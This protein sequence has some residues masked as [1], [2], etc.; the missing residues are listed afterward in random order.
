MQTQQ[1]S[2]E[3]LQK[4]VAGSRS[5]L[6]VV[7]IFTVLNIVLLL[8]DSG[9]YFLFSASGPYYATAFGI[10]MD[11]G[12]LQMGYES[13]VFTIIALVLSAVVLGLLLLCWGMSKKKTGWLTAAF[14]IMVLDTLV[15]LGISLADPEIFT[16]NILDF[17]FH[18]WVL[19]SLGS[20]MSAGKKLKSLPAERSAEVFDDFNNVMKSE[21]FDF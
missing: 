2:R 10:G 1:N 7:V 13:K 17:V 20:G 16:D 19:V 14:V 6:L 21:D 11:Y 4:K 8:L 12:M 5:N 15:L 9:R 18:A 3:E